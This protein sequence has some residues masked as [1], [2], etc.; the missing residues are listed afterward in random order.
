MKNI[1]IREVRFRLKLRYID[2]RVNHIK[3]FFDDP[4]NCAEVRRICQKNFPKGEEAEDVF[5]DI[6]I[7]LMTNRNSD[8]FPKDR[9]HLIRFIAGVV[10]NYRFDLLRK[11]SKMPPAIAI[12]EVREVETDSGPTITEKL[13]K[14]NELIHSRSE[15]FTDE[16]MKLWHCLYEC[17]DIKEMEKELKLKRNAI[18][19]L[20]KKLIDKIR[21]HFKLDNLY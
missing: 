11:E 13:D 14:L 18:Y 12:S 2:M 9:E 4:E 17:M 15:L 6:C 21:Q 16:Q 5:Q 1:F 3:R 7:K 8:N 10:I 20:K 19:V